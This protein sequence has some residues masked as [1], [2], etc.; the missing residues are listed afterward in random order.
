MS[1]TE[2]RL[3]ANRANALGSTGPIST[4]GKA[5]A[6]RNATR[7]GLLSAGLFLDDE[8][9][10]HFDMLLGDL[11]QS[12]APVGTMELVLV[13]R[14]AVT[15]WRQRRLV[16]A[17]TASV[18][19]A[20][21]ARKIAGGVSSELGR[22]Y[23]S[24]LKESEL[25]AFDAE[26]ETWSRNAIAEIEA[27]EVI[28]IV[29]IEQRAPLVFEQLKSDAEED[30]ED[31]VT[32]AEGH[33]GGLTGYISELLVWCRKQLRDAEARP[34]IMGLAEHV[35]AKRLVL[36]KDTLELLSRYQTTLDNQLYKALRALRD[37]QEW[38]LK[39][40]DTTPHPSVP[41]QDVI[42]AAA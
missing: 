29:S 24:E 13:E 28:D 34:Q 20:R 6:S 2:Q 32:F 22:G 4:E 14:I 5:I 41:A 11:V 40:I 1:S 10:A 23:G 37:A 36:P 9:P 38:R 17:E 8:D 18:S 31:P 25:G 3:A 39:T 15:L 21:Q 35:R 7:H 30:S 33:K 19:L 26:R 27:L 12:L 16:R 42:A